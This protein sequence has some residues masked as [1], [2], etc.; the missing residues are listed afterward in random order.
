[1]AQPDTPSGPLPRTAQP[2][3]PIN[4]WPLLQP[5]WQPGAP[6]TWDENSHGLLLAQNRVEDGAGHVPHRAVSHHQHRLHTKQPFS[7]LG[8][9]LRERQELLSTEVSPPHLGLWEPPRGR[10]HHADPILLRPCDAHLRGRAHT[11]GRQDVEPRDP[12]VPMCAQL[13]GAPCTWHSGG[14]GGSLLPQGARRQ[15]C[16]GKQKEGAWGP[17][18][19]QRAGPLLP[20]HAGGRVDAM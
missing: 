14:S 20:S 2:R 8:V 6:L 4:T 17:P 7:I 5:C 19:F 11:C 1:M 15:P 18:A 12:A 16:L 10:A 13:G 9:G 3:T